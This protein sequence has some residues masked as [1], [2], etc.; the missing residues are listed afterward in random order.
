MNSCRVDG[1]SRKIPSIRLVTSVTPCLWTPRVVM[2]PCVALITTATP[3]GRSTFS[4]TSA[5]C[6]VRR[7]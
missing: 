7:S 6:A 2:Q 1:L 3:C 4:M 5:I